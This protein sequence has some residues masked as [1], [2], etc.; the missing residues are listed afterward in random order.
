[1]GLFPNEDILIKKLNHG[2]VLDGAYLQ[3]KKIETYS[4]IC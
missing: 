4:I 2:K 3:K 1:M